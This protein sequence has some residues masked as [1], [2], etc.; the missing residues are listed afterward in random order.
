[1]ANMGLTDTVKNTLALQRSGGRVQQAI[2][3]VTT[4][5]IPDT[6][7]D[8]ETLAAYVKHK[9]HP[10]DSYKKKM[11]ELRS[12]GFT[13]DVLNERALRENQ[14]NVDQAVAWIID[15]TGD[16]DVKKLF[17]S[18]LHPTASTSSSSSHIGHHSSSSKPALPARSAAVP[19]PQPT[20]SFINSSKYQT[21]S[22]GSSRSNSY[23]AQPIKGN[24]P[25]ANLIDTAFTPQPY[26]SSPQQP[27]TMQTHAWGSLSPKNTYA[28]LND[29]SSS[30]RQPPPQQFTSPAIVSS[31][32]YQP[33]QR[34]AVDARTENPFHT[35]G[36]VP[37]PKHIDENKFLSV[38]DLKR[39]G[40]LPPAEG[41]VV[42]VV[43][44]VAGRG[45][46]G[47]SSGYS[48]RDEVEEDPF[49]DPFADN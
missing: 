4:D 47:Q 12:M 24:A 2:E 42:E 48:Q 30:P 13:D 28:Q 3:W 25:S 22:G 33:Q 27:A 35:V 1:M 16:A 36:F 31:T 46:G 41:E 39:M 37:A 32:L 38:D 7:A 23:N 17:Q 21:S 29:F 45:Y 10:M 20:R 19:S 49:A 8:N 26:S 14:N 43:Q 9:E 44:P 5:S 34:T 18:T 15:K 40:I 6:G 11:Q